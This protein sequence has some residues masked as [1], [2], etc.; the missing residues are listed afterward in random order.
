MKG[1][2]LRVV[3]DDE[4]IKALGRALFVF[5][6]LEWDAVWCIEEMS[7]GSI[8]LVSER[9][10]GGVGREL[11]NRVGALNLPL[12]HPLISTVNE[13]QQLVHVRNAICHGKPGTDVDGGQ[14]LFHDGVPWTVEKINEAADAFSVCQIKLNDHLYG[15]FGHPR[16]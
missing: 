2:S 16:R 13:F 7:P 12:G 4:Y 11:A 5:A 15:F 1:D 10:A 6:R 8:G 9:T 14:R 3:V